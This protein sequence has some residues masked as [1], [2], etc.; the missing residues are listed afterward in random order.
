VKPV[1][2]A[3]NGAALGS[4]MAMIASSD[5]LIASENATVGL[6]E[7]DVGLLGGCK[8][9][10]RLFSHSRLR[11]IALTGYRVDAKELLRL[12]VIE[13]CV[14][15]DE[16]MDKAFELARSIAVKSPVS[17][18]MIK[19]TLNVIEDLSLRDGYRYEQDMTSQISKTHDAKEAQNAFKEK[20]KA[21]FLGY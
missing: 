15:Q 14:P 8:H 18:K 7:V 20:R 21:N 5:I 19:H 12:G 9:A 17:T 16:L 10:E 11:R 13:Y 3:I 4:G 2:V 1:V 6:P